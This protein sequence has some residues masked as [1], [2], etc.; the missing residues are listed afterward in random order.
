MTALPVSQSKIA[1]YRERSK[2]MGEQIFGKDQGT[3]NDGSSLSNAGTTSSPLDGENRSTG[4]E[5]DPSGC[6]EELVRNERGSVFTAGGDTPAGIG[7]SV[8][9]DSKQQQGRRRHDLSL[10][11]ASAR[12]SRLFTGSY[13]EQVIDADELI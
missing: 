9:R 6:D 3:G 8:G 11:S 13:L 5:P 10:V 2:V 4:E 12:R 7:R 1:S